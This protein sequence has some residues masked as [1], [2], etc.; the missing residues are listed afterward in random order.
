MSNNLLK[1]GAVKD[2]RLVPG[3][4]W[5][6]MAHENNWTQRAACTP[7]KTYTL[8]TV[9]N[10]AGEVCF[11]FYLADGSVSRP[12]GYEEFPAGESVVRTLTAPAGA[13]YVA[14]SWADG[15]RRPMVVEGTTPAAWAPAD[16]ETLAG[17]GCSHER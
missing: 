2:Y 12:N 11:G 15:N 17:G 8:S 5:P 4:A 13:K 1:P 3:Y 7:G 10:V 14:A 9:T 6:G 16:G